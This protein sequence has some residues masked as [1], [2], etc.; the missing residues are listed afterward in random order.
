[1][2]IFWQ[3]RNLNRKYIPEAL[4]LYAALI[5][6]PVMGAEGLLQTRTCWILPLQGGRATVGHYHV[7]Q[8]QL[9]Y[10]G[11]QQMLG[12]RD[13]PARLERY[14]KSIIESVFVND[15]R[16]VCCQI[17]FSS[18]IMKCLSKL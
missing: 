3:I 9:Q 5:W 15:Y 14:E 1:M 13:H 11:G 8:S 12:K 18:E 6:V 17:K 16:Y 7:P 4:D 10:L 2:Q